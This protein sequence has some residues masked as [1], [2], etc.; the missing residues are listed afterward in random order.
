MIKGHLDETRKNQQ[1]NKT[2]AAPNR[3]LPSP[4]KQI[5]TTRFHTASPIMCTHSINALPL[6]P[7][8]PPTISVWTK[9]ACLLL[10]PVPEIIMHW[11]TLTTPRGARVQSHRPVHP[12]RFSETPR[13][14]LP[15]DSGR[16]FI[17]W[18]MHV[19]GLSKH[20]SRMPALTSSSSPL[21]CIAATVMQQRGRNNP[22]PSTE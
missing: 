19:P 8:Q 1:S 18:T 13:A 21:Q 7:D 6:F 17:V 16:T 9:L 14:W 22:T 20:S 3:P 5:P 4:N 11:K 15:P 12:C 2:L 10:H